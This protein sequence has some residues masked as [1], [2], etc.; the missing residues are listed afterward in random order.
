MATTSFESKFG[1][2]ADSL[3][4]D[5]LPVVRKS[6]LG[7]QVVATEDDNERA[8]GVMAYRIGRRL[9]FVPVF[10]ISGR[11]KGGDTMYLKEEDTFRPF[12]EVW[13]NYISTGKDFKSGE[14]GSPNG[15]R[16][17]GPYRVSTM[18][19]NWLHS[20]RA[21]DITLFDVK[22]LHK[23]ARMAHTAA[24]EVSLA[25]HLK[26]FSPK[27]AADLSNALVNSPTLANAMFSQYTPTE[28][29][30]LLGARLQDAIPAQKKA[31][32]PA[33]EIISTKDDPRAAGFTADEKRA[34]AR[35][36][37]VVRDNR[38]EASEAFVVKRDAVTRW[39]QPS[40]SGTYDVLTGDF[41]TKSRVI[42]R[43]IKD[44]N[45]L[46][47]PDHG[48]PRPAVSGTTIMFE[49][50]EKKMSIVSPNAIPFVDASK[51]P[52]K[53]DLGEPITVD[54]VRK[55]VIPDPADDDKRMWKTHPDTYAG[56]RSKVLIYDDKQAVM[57]SLFSG[58]D[59][60]IK[61]GSEWASDTQK[62]LILTG[63]PGKITKGDCWYIPSTVRIIDLTEY[64]DEFLPSASAKVPDSTM[65]NAGYLPVKVACEN[66]RWS[67]ESPMGNT[68]DVTRAPAFIDLV[69]GYGLRAK[70]AADL[71][72]QSAV[73][74]KLS[75]YVKLAGI[76]DG[77]EGDDHTETREVVDGK[78]LD[79]N[80][81]RRI[82]KAAQTGVKEVL[83]V[84][85]LKEMAESKY[86]L[87]RV[88]DTL[89][90]LSKALDRLC[91]NLFYFYWHN[92]QFEDRFGS[93]SLEQLEEA[94]KENIQALGDLVMYLQEKQALSE[95]ELT[96]G[97]KE[98][99]L[100]DS[101]R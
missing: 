39:A 40:V 28:L 93:Q 87:D 66:S 95:D 92:E 84:R 37:V 98:G 1:I 75:F 22:S 16:K 48:W 51:E 44:L 38:K 61:L 83:D 7:F 68:L 58:S 2:L 67:I 76:D 79:D 23:M 59:G 82:A 90:A 10:W 78:G 56:N 6:S 19:L 53:I 74:G 52:G 45:C 86:P 100:T 5:K 60:E 94:L 64:K 85:I 62:P 54:A 31:S 41:G 43:N 99:D 35:D 81:I 3:L 91:R 50:D 47:D 33:L 49:T 29:S 18:E 30:D 9:V 73:S 21:G 15:E 72:D 55:M 17:G 70:Q 13:V 69:S 27:A 101:M 96:G 63:H 32:V 80:S 11:L 12:T 46:D 88:A 57:G 8:I 71:L 77:I 89:P 26:A 24:G 25:D 34:L 65:V 20:K 36:G 42:F 97:D 14:V 4:G